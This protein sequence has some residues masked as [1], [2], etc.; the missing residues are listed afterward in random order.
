MLV[1]SSLCLALTVLLGVYY[2]V[3]NMRREKLLAETPADA[4][5]AMS[6]ENEEF[7]DRTDMED[8]LKFRYRW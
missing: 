1:A 2:K 5:A 3:Q 6:E 7:M 4:I 8:K